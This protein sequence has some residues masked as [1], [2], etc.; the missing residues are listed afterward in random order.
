[1]DLVHRESHQ[2]RID[3]SCAPTM[4][5]PTVDRS[6]LDAQEVDVACPQRGTCPGRAARLGPYPALPKP[7]RT[8][9]RPGQR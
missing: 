2:G 5:Q 9:S 7:C 4:D 1:V 6:P 8:Q 3:H